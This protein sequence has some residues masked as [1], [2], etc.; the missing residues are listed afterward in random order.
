MYIHICGRRWMGAGH[1]PRNWRPDSAQGHEVKSFWLSGF[2]FGVEILIGPRPDSRAL[3]TQGRLCISV[4][5]RDVCA[6]R[7]GCGQRAQSTPIAATRCPHPR[8]PRCAVAMIPSSRRVLSHGYV[9]SVYGR[10]PFCRS[11]SRIPPCIGN[12]GCRAPPENLVRTEVPSQTEAPI[13]MVARFPGTVLDRAR[14]C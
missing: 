11:R 12:S 9:R 3:E 1:T 2:H 4:L 10:V 6:L 13:P 14:P 5:R 7:E 8:G